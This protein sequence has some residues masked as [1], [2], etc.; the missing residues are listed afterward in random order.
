VEPGVEGNLVIAQSVRAAVLPAAVTDDMS[1]DRIPLR[2][3]AVRVLGEIVSGGSGL[4]SSAIAA[5]TA[6]RDH[7]DSSRV[8]EAA[9]TALGTAG[10]PVPIVSDMGQ[11]KA[12]PPTV[13]AKPPEQSTKPARCLLRG[14]RAGSSAGVVQGQSAGGGALTGWQEV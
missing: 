10:P 9:A 1:S 6:L 5:L 2:L 8:R 14:R 13:A 4:R 7:D 3:E 12:E 11:R